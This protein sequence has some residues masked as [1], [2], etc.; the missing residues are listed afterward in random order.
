M[1]RK[2]TGWKRTTEDMTEEEREE[3]SRE[4][5]IRFIAHLL[6]NSSHDADGLWA[7][8]G[9]VKTEVERMDF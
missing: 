6:R 1:T 3:Y 4:K 9:R 5:A 8:A 2:A 7:M